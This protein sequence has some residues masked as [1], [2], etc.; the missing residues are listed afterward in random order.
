MKALLRPAFVLGLSIAIATASLVGS[1]SVALAA[2]LV[3]AWTLGPVYEGSP[4]SLTATFS[5][6][7]GHG[8]YTVDVNWGD[9]TSEFYS[10]A[11]SEACDPPVTGKV[12]LTVQKATPYAN[13]GATGFIAVTLEDLMATNSQNVQFSVLNAPPVFT[14]FTLSA[15]EIDADGAVTATGFFTDTSSGEEHT[16][17]VDWDD[18]SVTTVVLPA[19]ARTFTETHTYTA[20]GNYTVSA[21]VTDHAFAESAATA[22]L[23]VHAPNQAPTMLVEVTV[24]SEG[25]SSSL[26][27][28]FA[29]ADA[30]DTHTVSIAWGDGQTT[31]SGTLAP[32]ETTFDATHVYADTGN[33]SLVVTLTDSATPAH[34]VTDT[35]SVSPT[36]V[37]PDVGALTLSPSSVVDHQALTVSGTFSDPGT[38]E[39]FTLIVDWGDGTSSPE[40][41]LGTDHMFSATH[42]YAAA[43]SFIVTATVKDGG[44]LTDSSTANV[45]VQPSAQSAAAILDEMS[46]LVQSFNLD[47]NTERWLLKKLADVKSSLAYGNSEVCSANGTLSHIL[48]FADRTLESEQSA[49]LS[50]FRPQLEG[51]AGCTSSGSQQSPKVLRA[52]TVTTTVTPALPQPLPTQKKDAPTKAKSAKSD[53]KPAGGRSSH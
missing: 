43:G 52:A 38:V 27:L 23:S 50:A 22:T 10:L 42:A 53:S 32:T 9:G 3:V 6:G 28:T 11:D 48:A 34:V 49:A 36:N 33:Y 41:S 18:L 14:S 30:L 26:A 8:P 45:D 44:G 39:T 15:T 13:E 16:L 2:N 5:G 19:G 29:D 47:R 46:S 4:V 31:N 35:R 21:T 1:S 17:K 51:A 12:C 20:A 37:G 40:A 25:G 7:A 24:G